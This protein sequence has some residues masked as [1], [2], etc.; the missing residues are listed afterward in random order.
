VIDREVASDG[1]VIVAA[2]FCD[3][4][5]DVG[6]SDTYVLLFLNRDAGRWTAV[7]LHSNV[8]SAHIAPAP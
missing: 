3:D 1:T 5:G 6:Q 2:P 8:A 4:S 7:A